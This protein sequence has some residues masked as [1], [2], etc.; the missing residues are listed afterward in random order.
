MANRL[1]WSG[2]L[3]SLAVLGALPALGQANFGSLTLGGDRQSGALTGST[4]GSTSLPAIVSNHD[5]DGNA[6]LGFGDPTPD[7]ILVLQK[8]FPTL[9]LRVSS[10]NGGTTLVVQGDRD[11]RCSDTTTRKKDARIS[12]NDWQAG[13][14]KIWVG[15]AAPGARQ[16]YTLSVS[17]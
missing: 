17:P 16:N 2:W 6:C 9:K 14:Y 10:D 3:L 11:S 7:H 1:Q 4:G 13:T 5:R 8:N 12:G 15:T